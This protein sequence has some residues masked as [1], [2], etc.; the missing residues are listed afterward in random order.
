MLERIIVVAL[1]AGLVLVA[2]LAARRLSRRRAEAVVGQRLPETLRDRIPVGDSALLYF[3]GPHCASCAQQGR[4]L[5]GLHA[6]LGVRTVRINATE[7][8]DVADRLGVMTVPTMALVGD[9][10]TVQRLLPGFQPA[11]VLEALLRQA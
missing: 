8:R 7:E 9:D 2:G 1:L 3:F 4:I 6:R 10:G 11:R 5:D